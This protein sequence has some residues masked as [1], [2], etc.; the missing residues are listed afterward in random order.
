MMTTDD[1]A[2]YMSTHGRRALGSLMSHSDSYLPRCPIAWSSASWI[3][4]ESANNLNPG[5]YQYQPQI[6]LLLR[7]ALVA[8]VIVSSLS[9][10]FS[11]DANS[12]GGSLAFNAHLIATFEDT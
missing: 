5:S 6:N 10:I 9:T 11:T 3:V 7:Y 4:L 1:S 8:Q 12:I 2:P